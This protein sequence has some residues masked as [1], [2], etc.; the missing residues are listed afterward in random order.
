MDPAFQ[1]ASSL[2]CDPRLRSSAAIIELHRS[3]KILRTGVCFSY[4]NL[5]PFSQLQ[6]LGTQLVNSCLP[7]KPPLYLPRQCLRSAR[8]RRCG[9]AAR[10]VYVKYFASGVVIRV[11][12]ISAASVNSAVGIRIPAYITH[13]IAKCPR[14]RLQI[15][16][17]LPAVRTFD[18]VA[19]CL[20]SA[21]KLLVRQDNFSVAGAVYRLAKGVRLVGKLAGVRK[22]T[23]RVARKRISAT[24]ECASRCYHVAVRRR[25]A[26]E[27]HEHQR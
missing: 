12:L 14:Y 1:S 11:M 24:L 7:S 18:L 3:I 10:G 2:A 16:L 27:C 26:A 22:S 21:P 25:A 8:S 9:T 5:K 4:G 17:G 6:P 19:E 13:D 15:G 20:I 23:P